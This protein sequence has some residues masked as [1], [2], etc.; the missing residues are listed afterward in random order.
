[1]LRNSPGDFA[2]AGVFFGVSFLA[3]S[4]PKM[5]RLT[6]GSLARVVAVPSEIGGEVFDVAGSD[7][8]GVLF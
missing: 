1:M 8:G 2:L 4:L 6:T 3:L 5:L 7:F